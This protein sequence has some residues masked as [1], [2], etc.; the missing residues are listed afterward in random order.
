MADYALPIT[1][2]LLGALMSLGTWREYASDN[3]R[4]AKLLAACSADGM[5]AGAT[6]GLA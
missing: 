2:A 5:L 1:I 3:R 4:N 6:V